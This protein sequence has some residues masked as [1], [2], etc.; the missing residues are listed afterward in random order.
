MRSAASPWCPPHRSARRWLKSSPNSREDDGVAIRVP[1]PNVSLVDLVCRLGRRDQG[2]SE[3]DLKKP[4]WPLKGS[5][6]LSRRSWFHDSTTPL[7]PPA[8]MRASPIHRGSMVKSS[9]GTTTSTGTPTGDRSVSP[10]GQISRLGARGS[11]PRSEGPLELQPIGPEGVAWHRREEVSHM[12]TITTLIS[13]ESEFSSEF[14][15]NVRW[16][17]RE[18]E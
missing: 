16:T 18:C 7:F 12:K 1:T 6:S 13:R 2:R 8:W 17:S 15:F 3:S 9:A 5:F 14:D 10:H 4:Q 11:A